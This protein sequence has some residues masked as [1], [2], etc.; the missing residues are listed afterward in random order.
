MKFLGQKSK[1]EIIVIILTVLI[2]FL[3]LARIIYVGMYE[4]EGHH[5]DETYSYGYANHYNPGEGNN[6]FN[7]PVSSLEGADTFTNYLTVQEGERFS[8]KSVINNQKTDMSPPLYS[9]LLHFVCSFFPDEFSWWYG[10]I[11]NMIMFLAVQCILFILGR[12]LT[13]NAVVSACICAFYGFSYGAV[14]C[15]VYIRMYSFFTFLVLC[16]MLL[17]WKY[18]R[19]EKLSISVLLGLFI[20]TLAGLLTHYYFWI[21]CFTIS[22]LSCI[23]WMLKRK[24]K[25]FGAYAASEFAAVGVSLLFF[26]SS[27]TNMSNGTGAYSTVVHF[28]Y[29]FDLSACL[30]SI[31]TETFGVPFNISR[32]TIIYLAGIVIVLALIFAAFSFLTREKKLGIIALKKTG[33]YFAWEGRNIRKTWENSNFLQLWMF[34]TAIVLVMVTAKVSYVGGMGEC[35]DRYMFPVMPVLILTVVSCFYHFVRHLK[36]NEKIAILLTVL[37]CL[38]F[39]VLN[40]FTAKCNYLFKTGADETFLDLTR[41]EE[42]IIVVNPDWHWEWY[43]VEIREADSCLTIVANRMEEAVTVM[44][45]NVPDKEY[46][47]LIAEKTAFP[48]EDEE[49]TE[50]PFDQKYNDIIY[51]NTL[52]MKEADFI[53]LISEKVSWIS[54]VE[55]MYE[56]DSFCGEQTVYK[57]YVK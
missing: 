41:G 52:Y 47:Y 40:Q 28:P 43:A 42:V 4:R 17:L 12:K 50:A 30:D 34:I 29:I 53:D 10:M 49:I 21:V 27:F 9:M 38:T 23:E 44:E 31:L 37:F 11:I 2:T 46:V 54:K 26:S 1:K 6:T 18:Y 45:E 14:N 56:R 13:G 55:K 25:L 7:F 35:I 48:K 15:F 51:S 16:L 33:H 39:A 8:F 36:G 57:V 24:W 22:A 5:S 19:S 20:V 32:M 3:Q